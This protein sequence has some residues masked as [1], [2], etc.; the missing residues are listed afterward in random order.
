MHINDTSRIF[1]IYLPASKGPLQLRQ[2]P[3]NE[4]KFKQSV[5]HGGHCVA[6]S[7]DM[8]KSTF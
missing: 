7:T 5:Y 3:Y 1:I 8:E 2:Y 6:L 4:S